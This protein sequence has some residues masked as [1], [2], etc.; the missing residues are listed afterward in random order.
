V[1]DDDYVDVDEIGFAPVGCTTEHLAL[2]FLE[3]A[4]ELLRLPVTV[5]QDGGPMS[6]EADRLARK[7]AARIPSEN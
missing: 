5:A 3:G 7:I 1:D 6:A 2:L 4:H